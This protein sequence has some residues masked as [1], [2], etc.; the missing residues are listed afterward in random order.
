MRDISLDHLCFAILTSYDSHDHYCRLGCQARMEYV[1]SLI[2][3][4]QGN[5]N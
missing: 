5:V 3:F 1:Y 4:N 2:I